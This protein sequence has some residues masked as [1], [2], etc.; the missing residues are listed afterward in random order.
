MTKELR[1]CPFCGGEAK[2]LTHKECNTT[3]YGVHCEITGCCSISTLYLSE[4]QAIEAWNR[5][6]PID[7]DRVS[8]QL[9][10]KVI[11]CKKAFEDAMNERK[12]NECIAIRI[13][14][15]GFVEAIEIVKKGGAEN[16][17]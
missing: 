10:E 6:D 14:L 3:Y 7:I 9:E 1:R 16:D 17:S 12:R 2:L 8:E 13:L 5:R 4:E 15:K 11:A